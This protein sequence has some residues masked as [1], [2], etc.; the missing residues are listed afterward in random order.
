MARGRAKWKK[1][2]DLKPALGTGMAWLETHAPRLTT[3]LRYHSLQDKLDD[4][5][6]I[7][8]FRRPLL[9][10]QAAYADAAQSLAT[11][12][13]DGKN[14][15][16][17]GDGI[18]LVTAL[19]GSVMIHGHFMQ[20]IDRKTGRLIALSTGRIPWGLTY[21]LPTLKRRQTIKGIVA[22][23]PP[24]NNF[25]HVL[26]DYLLPVVSAVLR[27]PHL[28][29][30]PI[31]LLVNRPSS[32]ADL[33]ASLLRRIGFE[34]HVRLIDRFETVDADA[35]LLAKTSAASTEHGYAFGPEMQLLDPYLHDMT[36]DITVPH[37]LVIERTQTRLRSVLN[38]TDMLVWLKSQGVEPVQFDWSNLLFQIACFRKAERI[39][40][41]HGAALTNLCWG[42]GR[43]VLEIFP[44]NARKTTYLHMASQNH[45]TYQCVFGSTEQANQN[46][47]VDLSTL[48]AAWQ[49]N[50][51]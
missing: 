1:L 43:N 24:V 29:H 45:H 32:P 25:Y 4:A 16:H 14:P 50:I 8:D 18:R 41:V 15:N 40:S 9:L 17:A 5:S 19:C 6:V 42:S 23:L 11:H 10:H 47:S 44:S 7:E 51:R 48:K 38:Q 22:A 21:P 12:N 34:T 26:V 35:Y 33:L 36:R 28:F 30:Q 46:F 3:G 39:I 13:V 2:F 49:G 37:A 27:Q 31:T 20:P